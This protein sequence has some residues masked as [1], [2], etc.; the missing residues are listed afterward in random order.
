MLTQAELAHQAGVGVV[1]V[2]R[3]E[4]DQGTNPRMS[5]VKQLAAVLDVD[6]AWLLFGEDDRMGKAAA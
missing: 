4:N 5:T 2:S 6:A 3:L 1:T